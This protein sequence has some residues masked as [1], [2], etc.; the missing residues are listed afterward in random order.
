MRYMQ[1]R[2]MEVHTHPICESCKEIACSNMLQSLHTVQMHVRA[3]Q[4]NSICILKA[5]AGPHGLP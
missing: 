2:F 3:A 4:A 5:L 1:Q